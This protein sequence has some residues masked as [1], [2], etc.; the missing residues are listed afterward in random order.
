[1]A[2]IDAV[3]VPFAADPAACAHACSASLYCAGSSFTADNDCLLCGHGTVWS[4]LEQTVPKTEPKG[5]TFN[6]TTGRRVCI[7]CPGDQG[8]AAIH[9]FQNL[10]IA[11]AILVLSATCAY[12]APADPSDVFGET[13]STIVLPDNSS[14]LGP[15]TLLNPH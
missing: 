8:L 3:L 2:C 14:L 1:M 6:A 10:R 5:C 12:I 4:G 7:A 11:N 15:G 13:D 9:G